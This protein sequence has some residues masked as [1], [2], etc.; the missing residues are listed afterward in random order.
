MAN[1]WKTEMGPK[2]C[3]EDVVRVEVLVADVANVVFNGKRFGQIS[4]KTC[5]AKAFGEGL[6]DMVHCDSS[7]GKRRTTEWADIVRDEI[8]GIE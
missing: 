7:G 1:N 4:G 2:M 3:Y 8:F 6:L 5:F